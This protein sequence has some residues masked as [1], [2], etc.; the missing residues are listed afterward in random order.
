MIDYSEYRIIRRIPETG[1][2][3][4]T[5]A[6]TFDIIL[7]SIDLFK[8]TGDYLIEGFDGLTWRKVK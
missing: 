4:V 8:I 1:E 5:F 3:S 6:K 2:N 7:R